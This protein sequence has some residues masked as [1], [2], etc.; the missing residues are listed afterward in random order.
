[1]KEPVIEIPGLTLV[2]F[3]RVTVEELMLQV[4][5]TDSTKAKLRVQRQWMDHQEDK[6]KIADESDDIFYTLKDCNLFERNPYFSL[7]QPIW[8]NTVNNLA[9]L[10]GQNSL[11]I[12][13]AIVCEKQSELWGTYHDGIYTINVKQSVIGV[14]NTYHLELKYGVE[15]EFYQNLLNLLGQPAA[16]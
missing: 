16:V 2:A 13:V 3:R 9:M 11:P 4:Q 1:M 7:V 6:L 12:S 14:S 5:V 15:R 10:A 8:A